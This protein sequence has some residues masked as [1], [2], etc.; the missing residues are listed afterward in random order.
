MCGIVG[1]VSANQVGSDL[2]LSLQRLE[3]RG[4]DSA[5]FCTIGSGPHL[6][7]DVGYISNV[8]TK[9]N[10]KTLQGTIGIG[11]TRWA[12]T[13][14]VTKENA[15]PH[16]DCTNSI[17]IVHNGI[18][19]NYEE[20]K[21]KLVKQGH[22]FASETDSE[23][24]AHYIEEKIKTMPMQKAIEH[25]FAD[26][27]GEFSVVVLKKDEHTLYAFKRDSPLVLGI[28]DGWSMVA[29]DVYAF[30]DKS[31][32]ALY[33]DDNEYAMIN[34]DSYAFFSAS[35]NPVSK[36]I[37]HVEWRSE[38]LKGNF[39]HHMIKEIKEQPLVIERLLQSLAIDQHEKLL[40][41]AELIKN[42]K[43]VYLIGCGTSYF[44]SLLGSYVLSKLGVDARCAIASE[45]ENY[46]VD[47]DTL[48]IAM[49]QSGETM[50]TIK[51]CKYAQGKGATIVSIVNTPYSTIQRMSILSLH[52]LAGHEVCVAATKTFLTTVVATLK[53]AE[54][55]GLRD[56]LNDL[57]QLITNIFEQE[58][59]IKDLA[60]ELKNER[61][62]YV[63][64]RNLMYP[65]CR[66]IALKIKEID[67]IH[68][69]GMMGGELKHGSL[70][71]IEEGTPVIALI[72][73]SP[74]II[75][76]AK[77]VQARGGKIIALTNRDERL[78]DR[79]IRIPTHGTLLF[80]L[81]C[82]VVGQ[83]LAYHIGKEKGLEIDKPRNIAKTCTTV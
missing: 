78:F 75:S 2:V 62:I 80:S 33:F 16:A 36:E 37:K 49:S 67:Y 13:G 41:F 14:K 25:F 24:I 83:L 76:N 26:A 52:T 27:K 57:P 19:S 44:A 22:Q 30:S 66:E 46:G 63:I 77:E 71:L 72:D 4:Y 21:A 50:D 43:R 51:A 23:V 28:G 53:I 54:E 61:D 18:L 40:D 81:L 39:D 6:V 10:Q 38:E 5:G 7:K 79:E 69:E 15:H 48:I 31:T 11:H 20:L 8:I 55:L 68:A 12:T 73:N 64:G 42:Q 32:E 35:G 59:I 56:Q 60:H 34:D 65:I 3:Y 82:A 17:F 74:E 58:D 29:S 45:F 9:E 70:T 47:S 1:I